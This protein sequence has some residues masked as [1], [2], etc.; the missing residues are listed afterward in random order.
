MPPTTTDTPIPA[1]T[2]SPPGAQ[3]VL[4][5]STAAFTLMFA[6]WLML[7]M[8]S[9]PIKNELG[10]TDGQFLQLTIAAMLAG[11]LGRFNFGVWTDKYGGRRVLTALLLLSV[12]P[13]LL[14]SQVTSFEQLLGCALL[15]GVAGNSFSVGIAWNAAWFPRAR[16]GFALGVFGAGNVGASVTK[17]IGPFLIAAIPAAGYFGGVVPGGWR[18][19]P[20]FYGTLLVVMAA[21]IWFLSPKVDRC[22]GR[23]RKFVEMVQP[24][25]KFRVWEYCLHYVVVFGAYV[26]FS[27]M[28]PMYFYKNY[29]VE[30]APMLGL[31][32]EVSAE[33]GKLVKLSGPEYKTALAAIPGAAADMAYLTKIIGFVVAFLY[34]FPASLLRPLGGYLSDKYGPRPVMVGVFAAML[35]AGTLLTAP[36]GLSVVPFTALLFVL[37]AGMGI[38]KASVYKLIPDQFPND[39]GAVGGLVGMLGA[40]GGILI[41]LGV[42]PLQAATG[43]PSVLFGV[44]LAL[45]ALST[46]IYAVME[47]SAR[48]AKVPAEV[49][50]AQLV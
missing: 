30:L 3:R 4:V 1:A 29:S 26:A 18:F 44:L 14:V 10:L 8:L 46:T 47:L 7:G 24:L 42:A 40:L 27:G 9:I 23:G 17:L 45:T 12:V 38:G 2:G 15:Y 21:A 5:L 35:F 32:P 28:L 20:V 39:V 43:M 41:P 33:V 19:I 36:L 50:E 11:S 31:S 34:V 37:G 49:A 48:K 6:V 13:T 16:Q 22:P 25:K